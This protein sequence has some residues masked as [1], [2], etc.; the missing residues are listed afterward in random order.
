MAR[1]PN[2]EQ[3]LKKLGVQWEYVESVPLSDI[4]INR[5]KTMQ[6]RLDPIDPDLI[7]DYAEMFN[8]GFAPP[9]LVLWQHG[10]SM[11]VPLD[12]NM[13]LA[14]NAQ[15]SPK[16]RLKAFEAY[17]IKTDDPMLADRICWTWNNLVNGKRLS[18]DEC[19]KHAVSFHRKYGQSVDK[20]AKEW[21]VKA[22]E[23]LSLSKEQDM[24]AIMTKHDIKL[25]SAMPV[26]TL[27]ELESIGKAGEDLLAKAIRI[28]ADNGITQ[29]DARGL[30]S[31]VKTAK[32][33]KEKIAVV[34]TFAESDVVKLARATSKGGRITVNKPP[35]LKLQSAIDH[36]D[37]I[38]SE[39]SDKTALRS[40]GQELKDYRAK[41]LKVTNLLID[42]Y[43]LGAFLS[44][45]GVD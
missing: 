6:A 4:N 9:P 11:K 29:K 8:E 21:G 25:K 24:I 16:N 12:G 35:R 40:I 45:Q 43:G 20:A 36:L 42:V 34:D 27:L 18:Y 38:L 19:L 13:R 14:G 31:K 41:A 28:V 32:T 5:G 33:A 22:W 44:G 37:S 23:V 7:D 10:K 15:A 3:A 1:Q 2:Y 30:A 39:Y 26:A 17:V